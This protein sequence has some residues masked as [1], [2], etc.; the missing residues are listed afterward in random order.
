M[1]PAEQIKEEKNMGGERNDSPT[2]S[3]CFQRSSKG[4]RLCGETL[5][6]LITSAGAAGASGVEIYCFSHPLEVVEAH[7]IRVHL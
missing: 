2:E 7:V 6:L 4:G 1:N 3:N 5:A